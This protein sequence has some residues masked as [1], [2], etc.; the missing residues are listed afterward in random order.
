MQFTSKEYLKL[1][2]KRQQKLNK[3]ELR[4]DLDSK[5]LLNYS[6]IITNEIFWNGRNDSIQ[7]MNDF[8]NY[9]ID[10]DEFDKKYRELRVIHRQQTAALEVYILD[11]PFNF[12]FTLTSFQFGSLITKLFDILEFFD[13]D[14]KDF[15]WNNYQVSERALRYY[16]VTTY[17]PELMKCIKNQELFSNSPI[18]DYN[19]ILKN[20]LNLP[21]LIL[22]EKKINSNDE[23]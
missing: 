9:K 23:F 11:N 14:W 16:I 6:R 12:K 8:I 4:R 13:P 15:R 21:R 3:K 1:L 18:K 19:S 17:L 2:K 22:K 5:K 7:I 20:Y 10:G